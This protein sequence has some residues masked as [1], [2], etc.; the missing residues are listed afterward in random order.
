MEAA[1]RRI[2]GPYFGAYRFRYPMTGVEP[3][4]PD[5]EGWKRCPS[6]PKGMTW[7]L[8]PAGEKRPGPPPSAGCEHRIV[9][10]GT[11]F[12]AGTGCRTLG[13]RSAGPWLRP[14]SAGRTAR[15][16]GDDGPAVTVTG[17]EAQDPLEQ[18]VDRPEPRVFGKVV[19]DA[20]RVPAQPGRAPG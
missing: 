11:R 14:S 13:A 7:I 16:A 3:P 6:T 12:S 9:G 17:Q 8:W 15:P 4:P 20:G 18:V 1:R 19:A 10:R 5:G 2:S